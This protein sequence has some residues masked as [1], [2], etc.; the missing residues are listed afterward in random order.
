MGDRRA[1]RAGE[2]LELGRPKACLEAPGVELRV[3]IVEPSVVSISML[4]DIK[5]PKVFL[6]RS[7]SMTFSMAIKHPPCGSAS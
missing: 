5:S 2:R 4:S 7:S 3:R 1:G 6:R